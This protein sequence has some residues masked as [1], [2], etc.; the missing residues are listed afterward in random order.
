MKPLLV[1]KGSVWIGGKLIKSVTTDNIASSEVSQLVASEEAISPSGEN[2]E[3]AYVVTNNS[4]TTLFL[5]RAELKPSE[6]LIIQTLSESLLSLENSGVISIEKNLRKNVI[7]P[8]VQVLN[9]YGLLIRERVLG[10]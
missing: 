4:K 8:R 2:S 10:Q 1:T 7:L 3:T 9:V 6:T 5:D